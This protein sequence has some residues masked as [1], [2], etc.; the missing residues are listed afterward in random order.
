VLKI[1]VMPTLLY[2]DVELVKG[3]GFDSWRRIGSVMQAV[4]VYNMREV[5]ELVFLDVAATRQGRS[6]DLE[7][8]ADIARECF[9]PLTVGGGIRSVDDVRS[10]LQVGADKVALNTAACEVP[11]LIEGISAQFGAQ[12]VV[13]SIDARLRPDGTYECWTRSGTTAAGKDPVEL[14]CEAERRGAGEIL[15]TSID[16]DGT[17]TGYDVALTQS[18]T[19]RVKIPVIASGGAGRAQDMAQVLAQGGASAVAAAACYHFTALTPL[20]VKRHLKAQG[21]PVRV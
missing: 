20:D 7:L 13:V 17:L 18:V 12:C 10:L 15:L 3:V 21:F 14:A 4:K 16:R 1:R 5:D 11:G 2:K 19:S 6:P 9:M 8:V